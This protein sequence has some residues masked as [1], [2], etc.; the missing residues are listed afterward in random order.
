MMTTEQI[1]STP[2]HYV[3]VFAITEI[4]AQAFRQHLF[5]QDA[6]L[7]H[8]C[9]R[10][11]SEPG[12][13]LVQIIRQAIETIDHLGA[14]TAVLREVSRRRAASRVEPPDYIALGAAFLVTLEG[15]IGA[16]LPDGVREAWAAVYGFLATTMQAAEVAA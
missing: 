3:Q 11:E 6:K 13:R 16:T 15:R 2:F 5:E 1:D 12:R 9:S 4:A 14:L 10:D 8:L 7:K